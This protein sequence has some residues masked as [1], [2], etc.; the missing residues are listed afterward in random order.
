[1]PGLDEKTRRLGRF[2]RDDEDMGAATDLGGA[3]RGAIEDSQNLIVICSP[4]AA[5]SEWV[6]REIL[7][8]KRNSHLGRTFAVIA[9]G[10]PGASTAAD[11]AQREL[12]CFPDA[13]RFDF[14]DG[15]GKVKATR[16]PLAADVRKESFARIRAR[17][18]AGLLDLP[19]DTLWRRDRRRAHWRLVQAA[20]ASLVLFCLFISGFAGLGIR[21]ARQTSVERS[22][23]VA[24]SAIAAADQG[25]TASALRLGV[26]AMRPGLMRETAMEAEPSL[27]RA[28]Q[29]SLSV[30]NFEGHRGEVFGIA[31][32]SDNKKVLTWAQD[33]TVRVWDAATGAPLVVRDEQGFVAGAMFAPDGESVLSWGASGAVSAWDARTGKELFR[34]VHGSEVSRVVVSPDRS[35]FLSYSEDGSV[36]LWSAATGELIAKQEHGR[37]VFGALFDP[38]RA[39][40][41][42]WDAETVRIWEAT[43]GKLVLKKEQ[44]LADVKLSPDGMFALSWGPNG[45]VVWDPDNGRDIA[46]RPGHV[47]HPS[48]SADSQR[49]LTSVGNTIEVWSATS[50]ELITQQNHAQSHAEA[51]FSP[52]GNSVLSW[53]L[54]EARVWDATTGRVIAAMRHGNLV[55]GAMFDPTGKLVLSWGG[56]TAWPASGAPPSARSLQSRPRRASSR[57]L[58]S[59]TTEG[60]Y[61]Q[62]QRMAKRAPGM[63]Q[64]VRLSTPRQRRDVAQ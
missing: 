32:S 38:T 11:Q 47:Q 41:I 12:E 1:V 59:R 20:T 14:E 19:F 54:D 26:F 48:F 13:L 56:E 24:Q 40:I 2:F 64:T 4:R 30:A 36:R 45:A 58:H 37:H 31:L 21:Q 34:Q 42:S 22:A 46:K 63:P 8:F 43:T 16:E 39:H 7:H 6:E 61:F 62:S 52:D 50:G 10:V 33:W 57:Q 51:V 18:I 60:P 27:I 44:G 5:K 17:L 28:M 15:G 49:V 35:R 55:K 29:K 25:D 53:D 9:S 23:T 3:L